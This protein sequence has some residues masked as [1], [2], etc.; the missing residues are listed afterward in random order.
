MQNIEEE[1]RSLRECI[2]QYAAM[3]EGEIGPETAKTIRREY[4]TALN[5]VVRELVARRREIEGRSS[6]SSG[7]Y[8]TPDKKR[9]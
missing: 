4:G 5:V 3:A 1:L 9:R 2:R 8:R 7:R 6:S